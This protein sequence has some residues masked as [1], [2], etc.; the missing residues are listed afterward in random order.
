MVLPTQANVNNLLDPRNSKV[1]CSH[2]SFTAQSS[3][4]YESDLEPRDFNDATTNEVYH[5]LVEHC[6]LDPKCPLMRVEQALILQVMEHTYSSA[7]RVLSKLT[8]DGV[9]RL[10]DW[11][12]RALDSRNTPY[13]STL[14]T[15]MLT[16]IAGRLLE[17]G[18]KVDI[19]PILYGPPG[20]RKSTLV[21]VLALQPEWAGVANLE[22]RDRELQFQLLGKSVVEIA[23]LRGFHTRDAEGIKAWLTTTADN[24][25]IPY[26]KYSYDRPRQFVTIGTTNAY[27]FLTE[28]VTV[29]RFAPV[30]VFRT[31][32]TEMVI[33][34][35]EQLYAEAIQ[36]F[37]LH[38]VPWADLEKLAEAET[39]R[40]VI[41]DP[42]GDVLDE[43]LAI[44]P[45]RITLSSALSQAIGLSIT[46][47]SASQATRMAKLLR[48]RGYSQQ[49][50]NSWAIQKR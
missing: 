39:A 12:A 48:S 38:G 31:I 9:P 45:A 32:N 17:P 23:E 33:Q 18:L 50:D 16:A 19:T 42:W 8:W 27:V 2:D 20:T 10:H 30:E 22:T 24:F 25:R 6:R 7:E 41:N 35:R 4:A 21:S 40:V 34:E 47:Q 5:Y 15:Y 44:A 36:H 46:R 1:Y 26:A 37:R 14:G 11:L 29:R 28:D 43:W 3:Y 49:T 13:L